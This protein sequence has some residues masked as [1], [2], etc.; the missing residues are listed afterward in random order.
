MWET[1]FVLVLGA[2]A[3]YGWGKLTEKSKVARRV[4]DAAERAEAKVNRG[5]ITVY[6]VVLGIL[7]LVGAYF[8]ITEGDGRMAL[9]ALVCGG[10][11]VYIAMSD[12]P[13]L[14]F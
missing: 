3:I 10:Y 7:T 9:G 12:E 4:E 11:A 1:I 6:L 8:A 2:A 13:W 5:M 14:I